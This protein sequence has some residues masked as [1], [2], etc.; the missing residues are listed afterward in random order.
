VRRLIASLLLT[1]IACLAVASPA[2]ALDFN[3]ADYFNLT[4]QPITFDKSQVAAGETFHAIVRG[5]AI[6]NKDIPLPVSRAT[7][8]SQVT[9]RSAAGGASYTLNTGFTIEINPFP[10]KAGDTF[11]IDE[12]IELRFP[13][14]A[15]PG[16]Y[17]VVWQIVQ[18]RAKISF[19]STD[20][21]DYIPPPQPMGKITVTSTTVTSTA[22]TTATGTTSTPAPATTATSRPL[23][24]P[25]FVVPWWAFPLGVVV[26]LAVIV[27]VIVV[28]VRRRR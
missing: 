28:L 17:Q 24:S 15:S 13:P 2:A 1:A 21:S 26:V 23:P 20:V 9:A 16:E 27:A 10:D 11:D 6:C 22:I 7:I 12:S 4:Y 14:D 3:P 8:V 19:I 25:A 18:A 5:R